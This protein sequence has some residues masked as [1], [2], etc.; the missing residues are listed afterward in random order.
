[1]DRE[2]YARVRDLYERAAPLDT[3]ER[4]ALL[5]R[6]CAGDPELGREVES[7]LRVS[8]RPLGG[9]NPFAS[10]RIEA[11]RREMEGALA[12]TTRERAPAAPS[13]AD[14]RRAPS[15]RVGSTRGALIAGGGALALVVMIG[16][17]LTFRAF[18]TP[19]PKQ[20]PTSPPASTPASPSGEI[21]GASEAAH[22][23]GRVAPDPERPEAPIGP[24]EALREMLEAESIAAWRA[25]APA[26]DQPDG[27]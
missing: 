11:R 12:R 25:S 6:E 14:A 15:R 22:A 27:P 16:V 7:L 13:A 19:P 2:R 20:P 10:E 5:A 4:S 9:A 8:E 24:S 18:P 23:F 1:M 26:G 17:P 21:P 3:P